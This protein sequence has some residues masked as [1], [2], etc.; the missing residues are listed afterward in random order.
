MLAETVF[1]EFCFSTAA[2]TLTTSLWAASI[3]DHWSV[4]THASAGSKVQKTARM[5]AYVTVC[6]HIMSLIE[7]TNLPQTAPFKSAGGLVSYPEGSQAL[8]E[9]DIYK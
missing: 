4:W 3:T 5:H 9:D 7:V 2:E 8:A 1:M 6:N